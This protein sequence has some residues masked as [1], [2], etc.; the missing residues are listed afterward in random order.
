[1]ER[2]PT[3]CPAARTLSQLQAASRQTVGQVVGLGSETLAASAPARRRS[4][5]AASRLARMSRSSRAT[6]VF[7]AR[8]SCSPEAACAAR[9]TSAFK[10]RI[11]SRPSPVRQS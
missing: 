3:M 7:S 11:T 10:A 8:T 5:R 9:G 1:M 4:S 2:G 6:A